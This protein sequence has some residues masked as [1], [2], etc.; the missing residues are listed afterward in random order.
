[1]VDHHFWTQWIS[2]FLKKLRFLAQIKGP[3]LQIFDFWQILG[4]QFVRQPHINWTIEAA[5][6][7]PLA[8]Q[9]HWST[10]AWVI[11]WGHEARQKPG[12]LHQNKWFQPLGIRRK[13]TNLE[14]KP[15][16]NQQQYWG[17]LNQKHIIGKEQQ[18]SGGKIRWRSHME[19]LIPRMF[20]S[21]DHIATFVGIGKQIY[22][23]IKPVS[24]NI[25]ISQLIVVHR[26]PPYRVPTIL[27]RLFIMYIHTIQVITT[28]SFVALT[29]QQQ[30]LQ[31]GFNSVGQNMLAPNARPCPNNKPKQYHILVTRGWMK[32]WLYAPIL[33]FGF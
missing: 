4:P 11:A 31:R 3:N 18:R 24:W 9:W 21:W 25:P 28:P 6:P 16:F 5:S 1:M 14:T 30:L 15:G 22:I 12:C 20:C 23:Y 10:A 29:V 7:V 8:V 2:G 26:C 13:I 17:Q 27:F 19:R 32:K 33:T